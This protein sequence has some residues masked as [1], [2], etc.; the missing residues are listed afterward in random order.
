VDEKFLGDS[1][2]LVKRFFCET[3]GP[4]A[5]LYAHPKFVPPAICERYTRVTKIPIYGSRPV[6]PFGI[7]LDPDKGVSLEAAT[8][9]HVSLNFIVG[10]LETD[11]PSYIVC[12]DQSFQR[13]G[14]KR[15]QMEAKIGFLAERRVTSFYYDSH[16]SFL[17]AAHQGST[18]DLIYKQFIAAG[19]P[20]DRLR[21]P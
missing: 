5:K 17:F 3:L 20:E 18:I 8:R 16:A 13:Q 19:I 10:L 1:Y 11:Q 7:L 9:R 2:D 12:Y 4:I 15:K 6:D 14:D 21:R